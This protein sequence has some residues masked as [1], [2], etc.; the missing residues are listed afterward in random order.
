MSRQGSYPQEL[1][2]RAVRMV[3]EHR[4]N[5]DS[6]WA[7]ITS[8]AH[9]CAF[10][11]G[12]P[13]FN[14]QPSPVDFTDPDVVYDKWHKRFIMSVLGINTPRTDESTADFFY[15][16]SFW[17]TGATSWDGDS[18]SRA[19]LD[20][21]NNTNAVGEDAGVHTDYFADQ[22]ILGVNGQGFYITADMFRDAS[23]T[24]NEF[25]YSS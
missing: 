9:R 2:E 3:F 4:D 23:E 18:W 13:E 6:Q 11:I 7:A 21:D 12:Y 14:C 8:I 20:P 10:F 24:G 22:P 1:H 25:I 17:P 5:Y 19:F 16:V 15:A